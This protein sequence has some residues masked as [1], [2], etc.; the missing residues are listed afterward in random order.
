MSAPKTITAEQKRTIWGLAKKALKI[1]DETLY[2]MICET[3]GCER[4]SSLTYAQADILIRELRRHAAGLGSD[5]LTEPQ[6][7]KI[8]HDTKELGW[9]PDGL[10]KFIK[11][12][13][14][15][16][17]VRWLTV[18]Q[19]RAVITA[20]EKIKKWHDSRVV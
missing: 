1:S 11:A 20:M 3:F 4:M 6:L 8:M 9:T 7:R 14:G 17:N 10:A 12:Q 5:R 13:T 15:V 18:A 16:D 19:A 2:A